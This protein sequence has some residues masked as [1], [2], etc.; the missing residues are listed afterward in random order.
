MRE[1]FFHKNKKFYHIFSQ[2]VFFYCDTQFCEKPTDFIYCH[3]RNLFCPE[4]GKNILLRNAAIRPLDT[5]FHSPQAHSMKPH[6]R[7]FS[8]LKITLGKLN[9]QQNCWGT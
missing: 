1:G 2:K 5:G 9:V 7:K 6:R 8:A 3:A 4:D